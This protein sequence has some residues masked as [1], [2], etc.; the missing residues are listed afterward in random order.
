MATILH[1]N[2]IFTIIVSLLEKLS[3]TVLPTI[4][5]KIILAFLSLYLSLI[6][7]IIFTLRL[8]K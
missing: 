4:Q 8:N 5:S 7:F 6:N 3:F 2:N 1:I